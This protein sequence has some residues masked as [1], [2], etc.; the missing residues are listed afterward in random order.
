[1][2]HSWDTRTELFHDSRNANWKERFKNVLWYLHKIDMGVSWGMGSNFGYLL[3]CFKNIWVV[4]IKHCKLNQWIKRN[5]MN[6]G[7][8]T[9]RHAR[10][11]FLQNPLEKPLNQRKLCLPLPLS[12]AFISL[13]S[14]TVLR[15]N[16][17]LDTF[18]KLKWWTEIP[19]PESEKRKTFRPQKLKC[20]CVA[21]LCHET[22]HTKSWVSLT[23]NAV[24]DLVK[25]AQI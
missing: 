5:I 21:S 17:I 18:W 1:M 10:G 7:W 23:T 20:S 13:L 15:N 19:S 12:L 9:E 2:I 14:F 22:E 8:K 16:T 25:D 6:T 3:E 11:V 24:L 4:F